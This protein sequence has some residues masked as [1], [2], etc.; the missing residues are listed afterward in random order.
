MIENIQHKNSLLIDEGGG[1]PTPLPPS[2][3]PKKEKLKKKT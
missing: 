2:L 1:L 3:T